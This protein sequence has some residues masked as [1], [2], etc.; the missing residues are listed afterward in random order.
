MCKKKARFEKAKRAGRWELD[1]KSAVTAMRSATT[2]VRAASPTAV[3]AAASAATMIAT[4]RGGAVAA[5]SRR[6][7][8][9]RSR[10]TARSR[11]RVV[12]RRGVAAIAVIRRRTVGTIAIARIVGRGPASGIVLCRA[13]VRTCP[14][15]PVR[16]IHVRAVWRIWMIQAAESLGRA[17]CVGGIALRRPGTNGAIR[18][19]GIV[20]SGRARARTLLH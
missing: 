20:W 2:A 16:R 15:G 11:R 4:T 1:Y 17:T 18:A 12:A 19:I 7:R 9:M 6:D 3:E 10:I 8:I 5:R 13:V 14:R